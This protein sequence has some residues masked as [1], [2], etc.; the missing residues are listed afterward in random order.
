MGLEQ[1][2]AQETRTFAA[3][4]FKSKETGMSVVSHAQGCSATPCPVQQVALDP[5]RQTAQG[6]CS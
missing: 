2:K 3:I 1:E 6:Q 4:A 5:A